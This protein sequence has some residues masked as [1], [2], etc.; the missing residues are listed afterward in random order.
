MVE[1]GTII[2][3]ISRSDLLEHMKGDG[4]AIFAGPDEYPAGRLRSR[5]VRKLME[6]LLPERIISILRH[7]GAIAER[8]GEEA[9]VVGGA[10]RD[11]L[12]RTKIWISTL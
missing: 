10:V 11:L 9:Y 12:L 7:A 2:G 5:S 6:E 8:R 1:D 3:V 4:A